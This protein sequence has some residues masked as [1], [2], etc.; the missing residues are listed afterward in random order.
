MSSE[1]SALFGNVICNVQL[2]FMSQVLDV[3]FFSCRDQKE[4][5]FFQILCQN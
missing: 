2:I 1:R 5:V 3:D 4:F